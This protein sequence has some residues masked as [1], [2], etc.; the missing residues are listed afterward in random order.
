MVVSSKI[1]IGFY[2]Q[3][4]NQ[5]LKKQAKHSSITSKTPDNITNSFKVSK[6]NIVSRCCKLPPKAFLLKPRYLVNKLQ[7][8]TKY[9]TV[10]GFKL[11][12]SKKTNGFEVNLRNDNR[13]ITIH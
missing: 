9:G 5:S 4:Y 12:T 2:N 6:V 13:K 7:F 1:T 11:K 3:K 10:K 8:F